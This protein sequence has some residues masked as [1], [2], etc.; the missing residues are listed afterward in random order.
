MTPNN[1]PILGAICGDIL[2]SC[3][4]GAGV[5]HLDHQLCLRSDRFTDD[6]VC[7]IAV[8]DAII[9]DLPFADALRKWC[10]KYPYVGYGGAFRHWF[11]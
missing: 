1:L 2:G 3:Y 10:R 6:T 4:E 7:T 9:N 8:T 11:R 5:K